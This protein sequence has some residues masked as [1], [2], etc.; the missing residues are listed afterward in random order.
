MAAATAPDPGEHLEGQMGKGHHDKIAVVTGAAA[1]LGQAFAQRLAQDG[2]H[3]VVAD[4]QNA[5][6]TVKMVEQAGREA[7]ACICDVS[8]PDSVSALKAE[9]ARRFG[10]CDILIN[11]AGIYPV[12]PFDDVTIDDWRRVMAI[13]L[14]GTFLCVSAFVPGMKQRGWG[15]IVN[16]AS[17]N[18]GMV[19]PGFTHYVASKGAIVGLTRA[20]ASEL[21]PHGIT[22]NAIAPSLTRT[23]GTLARKPRGATKDDDYRDVASRQ[24]VKHPQQP[25]DLVGTVS[26]L[27]SDDAAFITGQT[28]YVD[29]GL[30]RV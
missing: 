16:L 30:V 17:N 4:V 8:K 20:L 2:A 5:N 15:R 13:N 27:T 9:V 10:H 18:L 25:Q 24:A 6:D 3:I 11:N 19:V 14:D 26:F 21:G 1:G 29:G 12:Q 22:V 28:L 7:L 23:P